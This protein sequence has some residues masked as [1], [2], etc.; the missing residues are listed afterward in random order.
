MDDVTRRTHLA[1]ERTYLAWWRTSLGALALGIAVGR[2]LPELVG[3]ALLPYAVLGAL[4][5]VV[6]VAQAVH[7]EVR[8][9]EVRR[10]L[11]AGAYAHP[12]ERV[13]LAF[14]ASA[15]LLG[16]ATVALVIIAP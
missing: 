9:R 6:G 12:R 5:G 1:N 2:V 11:D 15:A 13:M 3:G 4:W 10:A 14:T 16:V 8:R 7:A